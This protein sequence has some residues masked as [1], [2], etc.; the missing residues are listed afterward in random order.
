MNI[1]KVTTLLV[2]LAISWAFSLVLVL[3]FTGSLSSFLPYYLKG[4]A[5]I[6]TMVLMIAL[7][8][9]DQPMLKNY[10]RKEA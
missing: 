4:L 8:C 9:M 10:K 3:L 7:Y 2:I 6:A 1:L 5:C